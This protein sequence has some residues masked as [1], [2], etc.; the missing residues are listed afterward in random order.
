M[1]AF[2]KKSQKLSWNAEWIATGME[3]IFV[4]VVVGTRPRKF[5]FL[6][7]TTN[8]TKREAKDMDQT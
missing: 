7:Q 6:K 5:L 1:N 2:E 4:V 3:K 8:W